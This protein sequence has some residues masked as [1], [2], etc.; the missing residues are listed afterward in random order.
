MSIFLRKIKSTHWRISRWTN[1]KKRVLRAL[2]LNITRG[3]DVSCHAFIAKSSKLMMSPDGQ[4]RG[5]L[6]QIKSGCRVCE[7]ALLTPYGGNIYLEEGV[8]IG[9]YCVIQSSSGTTL[10][11]GENTMIAGHT[12]IVPSNHGFSG[13]IPII[14]Q[15]VTSKGIVIANDVW[16]GG[17]VVILDGV[18]V[19]EGAVI[20]AGSVVTKNIP[21]FSIAVGNPAKVLRKRT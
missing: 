11:I 12:F 17:R 2:T 9:P 13:H 20:G 3:V 14:K 5:G 21:P 8:F 19:G 16:I 6:I 10:R 7:G 15:P 18:E 1:A 4:Y